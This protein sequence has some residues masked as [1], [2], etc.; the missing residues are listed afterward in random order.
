MNIIS[1]SSNNYIIC[2]KKIRKYLRVQVGRLSGQVP[3]WLHAICIE[4]P[5]NPSLHTSVTGSL[6]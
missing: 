1:K 6:K 3:S 5:L 4:D 2:K